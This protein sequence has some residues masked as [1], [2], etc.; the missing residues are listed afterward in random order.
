MKQHSRWQ[1]HEDAKIRA[2]YEANPNRPN[3]SAVA[4]ELDR[5]RAAVATRASTLE[6]S[7]PKATTAQQQL[8]ATLVQS[9]YS[10]GLAAEQLGLSKMQVRQAAKV[11]GVKPSGRRPTH[12]KPIGKPRREAPTAVVKAMDEVRA[13]TSI[14]RAAVN[15]SLT[16]SNL[17]GYCR[18]YGVKS[19]FSSG[20]KP[21]EAPNV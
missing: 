19:Q 1:A 6:L 8:A 15:N 4:V 17:T 9:G 5:T 10:L 11:M 12:T 20:R 13:G 16:L 14:S 7:R 21:K 18:R 3:L 2:A